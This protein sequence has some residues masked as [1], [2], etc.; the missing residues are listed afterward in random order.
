MARKPNNKKG[1][2]DEEKKKIDELMK[3]VTQKPWGHELLV[4]KNDRYV[5]KQLFVKANCRLSLQYHEKK[6]EHITLVAGKAHIYL[7]NEN[8]FSDFRLEHFDPVPID[9]GMI[10]RIYAGDEDAVIVEVSTT[11]LDDVVRLDDD[12]GR[13][14]KKE[15][16][17]EDGEEYEM[18]F[19]NDDDDDEDD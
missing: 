11:E 6:V 4:T 3:F 13:G 16:T 8:G 18:N 12:Y 2:S 17:D 9:A 10:H 5:V 7:E 19:T 15:K 14:P 1:A